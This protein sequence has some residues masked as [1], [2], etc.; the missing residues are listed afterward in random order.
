[1]C[2]CVCVCVCVHASICTHMHSWIW[3]LGSVQGAFLICCIFYLFWFRF[4]IGSL[5][6]PRIYQ[7]ACIP[8]TWDP[9]VSASQNWDYSCMPLPSAFVP[10]S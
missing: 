10:E 9:P 8:N 5:T 4:Q 3:R 7:S 1:V 2:V 6:E